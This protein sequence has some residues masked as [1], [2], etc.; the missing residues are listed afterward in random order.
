VSNEDV[1]R[2]KATGGKG[3]GKPEQHR[4]CKHQIVHELKRTNLT[5]DCEGCSEEASAENPMCRRAILSALKLNPNVNSIVTSHF[6]E[7]QYIDHSIET[8][9][10]MTA[11]IQKLDK[12]SSRDA[13][14]EHFGNEK[15]KDHTPATC[16]SCPINP[17]TML[18]DM[19]GNV[20]EN[21]VRAYES[22]A[23]ATAAIQAFR[24]SK[25]E[26]ASCHKAISDD[27]VYL[28]NE[29]EELRA[30]ILRRGF[31]IVI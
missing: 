18:N 17:K 16:Q 2:G 21:F 4:T 6:R 29:M 30:L 31:N 8:M 11:F 13:Y 14:L 7:I 1:S 24:P 28:F 27:M 23:N 25:Q 10:E 5:I 12:I 9:V 19:K 20:L 22:Y 3:K 15:R 26:C